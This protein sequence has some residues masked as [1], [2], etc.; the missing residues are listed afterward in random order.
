M[1]SWL[2]F[3]NLVI[4]AYDTDGD[5]APLSQTEVNAITGIWQIVAE[6][7]APFNINVTTVDPRTITGFK[8]PVSQIDIGGNGSWF[9]NTYGGYSQ[10]GGMN[11]SS[12]S[13]PARL[14][15]PR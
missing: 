13:N 8:G 4:P 2:G 14:L 3:T 9:G 15:V 11:G 10:V 6:N 1:S 12:P 5:G 7:Y